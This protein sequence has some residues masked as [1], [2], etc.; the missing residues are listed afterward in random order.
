MN[1]V[2]TIAKD[3]IPPVDAAL[4]QALEEA[5]EK[6]DAEA[7]KL[8]LGYRFQHD[9]HPIS[10]HF[11]Q[12]ENPE[13]EILCFSFL[14]GGIQVTSRMDAKS[15]LTDKEI[16]RLKTKAERVQQLFLQ[17]WFSRKEARFANAKHPLWRTESGDIIAMI[18]RHYQP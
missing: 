18:H 13:N 11:Y 4:S 9:R 12:A 17:Y 1:S 6:L 7:D 2:F 15:S 5:G 8:S 16:N 14:G 10:F 3:Q